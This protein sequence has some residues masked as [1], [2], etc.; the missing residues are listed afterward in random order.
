[1]AQGKMQSEIFKCS[2]DGQLDRS[3]K[4]CF[5]TVPMS[6]RLLKCFETRGKSSSG[7]PWRKVKTLSSR[8]L[9]RSAC[10][11]QRSTCGTSPSS[12]SKKQRW[13]VSN[14]ELPR[15]SRR[16]SM[17]LRTPPRFNLITRT[18]VADFQRWR[19]RRAR[20]LV[21]TASRESR[22]PR[23]WWRTPSG[24]AFMW[25]GP[26]PTEA[27]AWLHFFLGD[28]PSNRSQ[29]PQLRCTGGD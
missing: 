2:S 25:Q 11:T 19:Q 6:C 16:C 20:M 26:A 27:I 7:S 5:N 15:R 18:A 23:M 13:N 12:N 24:R 4:L 22:K 9:H 14:G 10:R 8:T 21:C 1:M 29:T 28:I 3:H 17:K